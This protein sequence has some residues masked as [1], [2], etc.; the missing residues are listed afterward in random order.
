MWESDFN[1]S[2]LCHLKGRAVTDKFAEHQDANAPCYGLPVDND[3]NERTTPTHP[4]TLHPAKEITGRMEAT[5]RVEIHKVTE[6][7]MADGV[8]I[9]QMLK[10]RA[11]SAAPRST[12]SRPSTGKDLGVMK[13]PGAQGHQYSGIPPSISPAVQKIKASQAINEKNSKMYMQ[14][15]TTNPAAARSA[16]GKIVE[17]PTH[18]QSTG[19]TQFGRPRSALQLRNGKDIHGAYKD[20]A[21]IASPISLNLISSMKDDGLSSAV[22]SIFNSGDGTA[23]AISNTKPAN[24]QNHPTGAI[25]TTHPV[26]AH[27]AGFYSKNHFTSARNAVKSA[28]LSNLLR[29]KSASNHKRSHTVEG[30]VT[31]ELANDSFVIGR[32]Q[33]K[34]MSGFTVARIDVDD[35][36]TDRSPKLP[37]RKMFHFS[38]IAMI[39]THLCT[40]TDP[41]CTTEQTL[42]ALSALIMLAEDNKYHNRSNHTYVGDHSN[43][44][45]PGKL[46][47][48]GKKTLLSQSRSNSKNN[49]YR[50]SSLGSATSLTSLAPSDGL[51]S[52]S[53]ITD[54]I[55]RKSSYIHG[56]HSSNANANQIAYNISMLN[57][58]SL[59]MGLLQ[60]YFDPRFLNQMEKMDKTTR[61]EIIKHLLFLFEKVDRLL[62]VSSCIS[63]DIE[64]E[65]AMD[66]IAN[67]AASILSCELILM[68]LIDPDTGE[69]V[70]CEYD[71]TLDPKEKELLSDLRFPAGTG[72]AGWVAQ[73]DEPVN[74]RDAA[75]HE[76]FDADVDTRGAPDIIPHS[77]M[78][79]PIKTRENT[80]KGVIEAV[81]KIGQNG[82]LQPFNHEDEFLL[83]TLCK[84]AGIII[85]NAQMYDTMKKTQKKVEVLLE[86]TRSLGST[87]ELDLLVK[88]IMDAAKELLSADRCTLF[89]IDSKGKQLRAH[90]Q[91]RDIIQ[92]I[93][94]PMNSG[95]AGFVFT[96]GSSVNI[97][98]AYKDSR[99]NPEVDRQTGYITRNILCMPIKN[100]S[101]EAIGV[102]QMIN[103]KKGAFGAED[104]KILTAVAIEK[105]YLFK[106]TEDM[107]RETSQMKNYLSM[108]LQSITN[109]VLTLDGEGHLSHIN[110]PSK[111]EMESMLDEM[112]TTHYEKWLGIENATFISDIDRAYN[113]PGGTIIAQDYELCL[114]GK[115]RNVNYTIVQM[116]TELAIGAS[117]NITGKSLK[118]TATYEST[119]VV[120]VLEDISSEKR[121]LM[122]LGRYMSPAL[123]KQVMAEDGGQLGGK[124]KKV[125]ILFS[126]IRSFTTL[127]ES[128]EPHEVV[129]LLNHHF[130]DAVNAILAE[131]GILDKYIGDAV[132]AVFGVPF[133]SPDDSI[134]ACNAALRMK[135]SLA[136]FNDYRL[137]HNQKEIKI[138]IGLNTGMVLSGNIGSTK[139]MEFSC[140]GDAVNLSSRIEGLTKQYHVTILITEHTL[141]ETHDQF[142]TREVDQV[143]VTG[144]STKVGI[145][146]LLGRKGDPLPDE[147]LEGVHLF[148]QGLSKYRKRFFKEAIDLF[149][150]AIRIADDGPSKTLL[151]RC[152]NYLANPPQ[153]DWNGVYVAEGK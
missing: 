72:I 50:A 144:K 142:I 52:S 114:D 133:V 59:M 75:N 127:S 108:I 5:G 10:P 128:M 80:L 62:A 149:E 22:A 131:Q 66:N 12:R 137:K 38:D 32:S 30:I 18:Q 135:E 101:G 47:T 134:H 94:I 107:L 34:D 92:E 112:K 17:I 45:N 1:R 79:F 153:S 61:A 64:L 15:F 89:L 104:E 118:D 145:Y 136:I 151:Q 113:T 13:L 42:E 77:I 129:E 73:R 35:H 120:I 152:K 29:P 109:V 147:V 49:L 138:G 60:K 110:H 53:A 48:R 68:Y 150:T 11:R 63:L 27:T 2:Y 132:M 70:V 26:G 87:L 44:R 86:T 31:E 97:H 91:G 46:S 6:H 33:N 121:A 117:E 116:T 103:R 115:V 130:S 7:P 82:V 19:H 98:D 21:L 119:G 106:K 139:R 88:M 9:E 28:D 148:L 65:D 74:I 96:S 67:E 123:A 85:N 81:N 126:D 14:K 100:I 8:W 51:E 58:D 20:P 143:V 41:E 146:E 99:F 83:K 111:M 55:D 105:S 71:P 24:I 122:T 36:S 124:R 43:N 102:T 125:A 25:T 56:G 90:I 54:R 95:I 78:C 69:L 57:E 76:H 140:I 93:R 4:P 84:Q 23:K 141:L 37:N 3:I 40:L 16:K 39:D